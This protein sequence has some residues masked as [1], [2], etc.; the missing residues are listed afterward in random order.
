M[1]T[2]SI[3]NALIATFNNNV[4]K[5]LT[6]CNSEINSILKSRLAISSKNKKIQQIKNNFNINYK[7]LKNK[8]NLDIKA[9]QTSAA[10][11]PAPA[12]AAPAPSAPA[13]AP[14]QVIKE[15]KNALLIG[16][17]YVGS[18]YQLYGCINDVENIQNKL[19]SQ[20]NFNNVLIM[21]DNTSKKPTKTNILNEIKN[22]L[23][24]AKSGDKLFLAF[25]GHGSTMKDTNGDEKDGLDE[26]FVPLDFNY[27]S[28]DEIKLVINNYLK[29]DVTLF[30]LF[31]CCHSGTILDLRYQY[32]DS[33]NYDNPSENT[34]ET[35]T[36]G[37]IIMISGCRDNQTSADAYINSKS[38]G[39]M[40]WAF[41]DTLN[42]NTS[43][44][45]KDLITTMRSSL[46]KSD[47]EQTP[48][49]S[50]GNKLDI[51]TKFYLL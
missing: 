43:L 49:L 7:K 8:L 38:Q 29:K 17:N 20:Y 6:L 51:N 1:S 47:Y 44:T 14:T 22:L 28:D 27:I 36:I 30:A 13:P 24:N 5:L 48:Q 33:E 10:P 21:S 35:E 41:L 34:K 50:S 12:P 25:S 45:W 15:N 40:T 2:Q 23:T 46:L 11:P 19:K 37:N 32:L 3:I 26:C 42:N 31:D 9:A 16:C 4:N 39:A 18:Q